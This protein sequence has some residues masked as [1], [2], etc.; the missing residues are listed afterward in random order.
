[1]KYYNLARNIP[2]YPPWL[3]LRGNNPS[4]LH[5]SSFLFFGGDEHV[6]STVTV[7]GN[8]SLSL[9]DP[10]REV[11]KFLA[12]KSDRSYRALWSSNTYYGQLGDNLGFWDTGKLTAGTPKWRWMVQM[13]CR[14]SRWKMIFLFKWVIFRFQPLIFQ[15]VLLMV[16]KSGK[17]TSWA[18]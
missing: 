11:W 17:L 9:E 3:E 2:R 15:G 13:I 6:N 8:V 12:P 4:K 1:M 18:W 5:G 16:Q 14:I 7:P 10:L